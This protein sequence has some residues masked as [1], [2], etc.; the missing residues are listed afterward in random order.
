MNASR[1]ESIYG[2]DTGPLGWD[3]SALAPLIAYKYGVLLAITVLLLQFCAERRRFKNA[4][5]TQTGERISP[6]VPY[7]FPLLG[8]IPITY[9]LNPLSFVLSLR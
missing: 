2:D 3:M 8:T 4:R 7:Y 5:K 6:T 1:H 9:L